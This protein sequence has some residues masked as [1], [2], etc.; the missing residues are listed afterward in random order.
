MAYSELVV[1]LMIAGFGAA[2]IPA[3][4]NAVVSSVEPAEIGKASGA[5]NMLRQLGA[6]FGVAILAAVFAQLGSFGTAQTLS[7]GSG[8]RWRCQLAFHS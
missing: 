2:V 7:P 1:P 4:Q 8:R 5:F 3:S 6:A